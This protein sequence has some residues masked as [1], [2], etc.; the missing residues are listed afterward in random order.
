M[1]INDIHAVKR[2]VFK[3]YPI[4]AVGVSLKVEL[5]SFGQF[6]LWYWQNAELMTAF[7]K[8][9]GKVTAAPDDGELKP[10]L[11]E[12]LQLLHQK[13][14]RLKRQ[15][16]RLLLNG[17]YLECRRRGTDLKAAMRL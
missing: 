16:A 17:E 5:A 6:G 10:L 3:I 15:A 9:C 1:N 2:E 7:R 8:L 12:L 13:T 11:Q 14:E 4:F